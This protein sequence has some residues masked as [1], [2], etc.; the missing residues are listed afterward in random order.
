MGPRT[1]YLEILTCQC[2]RFTPR[3][4]IP[5]ATRKPFASALS[6]TAVPSLTKDT[7][8]RS[9]TK[10]GGFRLTRT[11]GH[12]SFSIPLLL[13]E[14]FAFLAG[15]GFTD[16][17]LTGASSWASLWRTASHLRSLFLSTLTSSA[18][19]APRPDAN[20]CLTTTSELRQ[21]FFN[22]F[23]NPFTWGYPRRDTVSKRTV[24]ARIR[25]QVVGLLSKQASRRILRVDSRGSLYICQLSA[26]NAMQNLQIASTLSDQIRQRCPGASVRFRVCSATVGAMIPVY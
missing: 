24:D 3:D 14:G 18:A 16:R 13:A 9:D 10:I 6:S 8:T 26:R 22:T 2:H 4:L 20:K 12:K 25:A 7:R 21:G 5:S 17:R 1:G 15:V 11:L 23:A 19:L